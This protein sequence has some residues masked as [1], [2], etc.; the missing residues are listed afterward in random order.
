MEGGREGR[1]GMLICYSYWIQRSVNGIVEDKR[2]ELK[3]ELWGI[4]WIERLKKNQRI[5]KEKNQRIRE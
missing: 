3:G 5:R 4:L 1:F 2:E